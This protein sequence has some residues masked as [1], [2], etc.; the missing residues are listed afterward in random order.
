MILPR[1]KHSLDGAL[2]PYISRE[3]YDKV[4]KEF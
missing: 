2:V 1:S 4:A 3:D